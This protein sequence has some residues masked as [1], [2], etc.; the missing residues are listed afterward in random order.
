[1][2]YHN[3]EQQTI[4][5]RGQVVA[6]VLGFVV[7]IALA[8]VTLTI[9]NRVQELN[10]S[11]YINNVRARILAQSGIEQAMT[12]FRKNP[13]TC[14]I[15]NHLPE[16]FYYGED[17]N[18]NNII[19]EGEDQND[20]GW[21]DTVECPL[22]RALAP[23]VLSSLT[24][25]R[26]LTIKN[27]G[28]RL[29]ILSM[30]IPIPASSSAGLPGGLRPEVQ[31]EGQTDTSAP[32]SVGG[33]ALKITDCS[34]QIYLNYSEANNKGTTRLL[35]NLGHFLKLGYNLGDKINNERKKFSKNRFTVKEELRRFINEDDYECIAPY[36]TIY[37]YLNEKVIRPKPLAERLHQPRPGT[38]IRDYRDLNPGRLELEPRVPININTAPEMVLKSVLAG[39]E[40][41]YL[42][43]LATKLPEELMEKPPQE[44]GDDLSRFSGIGVLQIVRIDPSLA[45]NVAR[46]IIRERRIKPFL[47]WQSFNEFCDRLVEEGILG[48]INT[49]L[50][51]LEAQARADLIKANANPNTLL[52]DFNPDTAISRLVDKSDLINYTTE[53]CF[54]PQGYFEIESLGAV[55]SVT[56]PTVLSGRSATESR[57][58]TNL[59]EVETSSLS[60]HKIRCVIKIFDMYAE[61][62]Q[63]DFSR[64]TISRR[65]KTSGAEPTQRPKTLQTY[66]EPDI[67]VGKES[68]LNY[69]SKCT[70]DGQIALATNQN[71]SQD[72]QQNDRLVFQQHFTKS[73]TA[74]YAGGNPDPIKEENE[75]LLSWRSLFSEEPNGPGSLYP[76]GVYSSA[77][78]WPAFSAENN[79]IDGPTH[80][81]SFSENR[82]RG[83]ISFWVKPNYPV[84]G[85]PRQIFSINK[86]VEAALG[87]NDIFAVFLFPVFSWGNP[88]KAGLKLL[89]GANFIWIWDTGK[90]LGND[91]PEYILV[92]SLAE[93][94]LPDG[95]PRLGRDSAVAS[96]GGQWYHIGLAWD[97]RPPAQGL[98]ITCPNCQGRGRIPRAGVEIL[99]SRCN[100]RGKVSTSKSQLSDV[101]SFCVNGK[102][103]T[104]F[105]PYPPQY[106]PRIIQH[107]AWAKNNLFRLGKPAEATIDEFTI[108]LHAS[109]SRAKEFIMTDYHK[110]RYYQGEGVF[111][112]GKIEFPDEEYKTPDNKYPDRLKGYLFYTV[113]PAGAGLVS[114]AS[115]GEA[116][117][118]EIQLCDEKGL[119]LTESLSNPEGG[120]FDIPLK[121]GRLGGLKY[122]IF[123]RQTQAKT[124]VL[125]TPFFDDITILFFKP[126][127]QR[128][129]EY[130]VPI[131]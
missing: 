33:Y 63:A 102:E 65:P 110:G 16:W 50:E 92:N 91:P 95:H 27:R 22:E 131:K 55:G 80:E 41:F 74:A 68:S 7:V 114:Q 2:K 97:S 123:F 66:P 24:A 6:V 8:V 20:N 13:E 105:S 104:G 29:T 86:P 113:Y 106:P 77:I 30:S 34:S 76:D 79:F 70:V 59:P 14:L 26:W 5:Q 103:M 37:G 39:L 61:T 58:L 35:N 99:C 49:P 129:E 4:V 90:H 62:T 57:G 25:E 118:I 117:K 17:Y 125:E 45:E 28:K 120:N 52:N 11:T 89:P 112:S 72:K 96:Q 12:F 73:F 94:R 109:V 40:G 18:R 36:V 98:D 81:Q 46:Q 3:V 108:Q 93:K 119:P 67:D 122:K 42:N 124:P 44:W 54:Q 84:L 82:F 111:T 130:V 15:S 126:S 64:G 85:K 100:G 56:N 127:F 78:S 60:L 23:S 101:I 10:P 53:F 38:E 116:R 121:S 69:A 51:R 83:T 47:A 21:L 31:P 9:I 75:E 107:I 71:Q 87:G 19:D 128:L 1:M 115:P 88:A 48:P 43:S 32:N